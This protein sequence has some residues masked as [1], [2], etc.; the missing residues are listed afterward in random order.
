MNNTA[1][2]LNNDYI[3]AYHTELRADRSAALPI[4]AARKPRRE[5]KR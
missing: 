2:T 5:R 3:N 4:E 1:N